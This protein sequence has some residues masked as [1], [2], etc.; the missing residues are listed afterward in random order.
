MRRQEA[1]GE[2]I[3]HERQPTDDDPR[4]DHGGRDG[5]EESGEQAQAA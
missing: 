3:A 4:P 5:D 2:R 1:V